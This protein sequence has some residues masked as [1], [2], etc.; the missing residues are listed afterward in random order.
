MSQTLTWSNHWKS[1]LNNPI[2]VRVITKASRNLVRLVD[3]QQP[4]LLK[5]W[6]TVVPEQGK[7]NK[8]ALKLLSK[9]LNVPQSQLIITHGHNNPLKRVQVLCD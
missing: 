5:V 6:V 3:D 2:D 8:R 1:K 9:F 7:A 4:G